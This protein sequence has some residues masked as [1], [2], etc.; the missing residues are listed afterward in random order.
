M[1]MPLHYLQEEVV[2]LHNKV[3]MMKQFR[4]LTE[5]LRQECPFLG[6]LLDP[7]EVLVWGTL[8]DE[9]RQYP[10]QIYYNFHQ[11]KESV[12]MCPRQGTRPQTHQMVYL[13]L[14]IQV[15]SLA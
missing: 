1:R 15:S 4:L 12:Q 5:L 7:E 11:P 6:H 3:W 13:L 8:A 2:G 10:R 14:K 9:D